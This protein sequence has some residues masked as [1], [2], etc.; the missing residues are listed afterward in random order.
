MEN[1]EGEPLKISFGRGSDN[2]NRQYGTD[3]LEHL[4]VLFIALK[5]CGVIDWSWWIVL[6]PLWIGGALLAVVMALLWLL[7][8]RWK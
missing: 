3:F 4:A 6:L 2:D 7:G 1:K 5:L 8:R